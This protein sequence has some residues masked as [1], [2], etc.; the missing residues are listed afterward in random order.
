MS[1]TFKLIMIIV[2]IIACLVN[3]MIKLISKNSLKEE[4]ISSA[5]YMQK[6]SE[7]EQSKDT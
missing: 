2:L 6:V 4:L 5:T 1:R 7:E 3:I